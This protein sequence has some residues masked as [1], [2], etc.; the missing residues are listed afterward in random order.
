[1]LHAS[2]GVKAKSLSK[3]EKSPGLSAG[4]N[5]SV[6]DSALA[7]HVNNNSIN[8]EKARPGKRFTLI[9]VFYQGKGRRIPN[10]IGVGIRLSS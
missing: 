9:E 7:I 5:V 1:M 8:A 10:E 4:V 2:P 3:M 6:L